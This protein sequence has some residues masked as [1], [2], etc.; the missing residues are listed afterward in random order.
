M[1]AI[2]Q[3]F[4]CQACGYYKKKHLSEWDGRKTPWGAD[5]LKSYTKGSF[6]RKRVAF[7]RAQ[8][9]NLLLQKFNILPKDNSKMCLADWGCANGIFLAEAKK[10]GFTV[11]GVETSEIFRD[12]CNRAEGITCFGCED[13]L[14]E[15]SFDVLTCFDSIGYTTDLFKTLNIFKQTLKTNSI[16]MV[17]AGF[18]AGDLS[19]VQDNSFNYFFNSKFF[20]ETLPR[21]IGVSAR[22]Y[23][24]ED[25]NFNT[26]DSSVRDIDWWASYLGM[27]G[28]FKMQYC[29]LVKTSAANLNKIDSHEWSC[30]SK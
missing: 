7:D 25:R 24:M 8:L 20:K 28:E 22:R 19:L 21:F 1:V 9:I 17:S 6:W 27:N 2:E 10:I 3:L 4:F 30:E 13:D 14:K 5:F 29:I 15:I 16:L 23:W 12:E 11:Y 18:F 26:L